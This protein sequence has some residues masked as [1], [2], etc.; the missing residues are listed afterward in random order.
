MEFGGANGG[1]SDV[2]KDLRFRLEARARR[3]AAEDCATIV[4]GRKVAKEDCSVI[5]SRTCGMC[6]SFWGDG[7][8]VLRRKEAGTGEPD[9]SMVILSHAGAS[10]LVVVVR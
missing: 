8:S 5:G 4:V 6:V 7:V 2:E 9:A 10:W 1:R 3:L